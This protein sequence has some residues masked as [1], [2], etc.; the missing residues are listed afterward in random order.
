MLLPYVLVLLLSNTRTYG[1]SMSWSGSHRPRVGEVC[2]Y[3]HSI[4]RQCVGDMGWP[5]SHRVNQVARQVVAV[6]M[7][8]WQR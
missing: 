2:I 1:S 7:G 8:K 3:N 6:N 5:G 4:V